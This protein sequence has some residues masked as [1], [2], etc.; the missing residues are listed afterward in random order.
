MTALMADGSINL[1][2]RWGVRQVYM[3][4]SLFFLELLNRPLELGK[5]SPGATI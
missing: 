2:F 4:F 5:L 3:Q 1:Q